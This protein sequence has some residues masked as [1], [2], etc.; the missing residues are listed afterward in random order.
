M[1][2]P[3]RGR[4]RAGRRPTLVKTE[5]AAVAA[6]QAESPAPARDRRPLVLL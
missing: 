2:L 3:R 4:V 5:P 1:P 6:A